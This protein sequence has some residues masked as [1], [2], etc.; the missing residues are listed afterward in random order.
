MKKDEMIYIYIYIERERERERCIKTLD[1]LNEQLNVDGFTISKRGL[2]LRLLPKLSSLEGQ[3]V[4]TVPVKL[5]RAQNDKHAKYINGLFCTATTSHLEEL[6]SMLGPMSQDDKA[7]VPFSLTV[8]NKQ[9][10]S[11]M[12]VEYRVS[13]PDHDWVVDVRRNSFSIFWN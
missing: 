2:Y 12:R 8:A 1:Q 6:A 7:R 13:L 3:H 4:K 9:S 10:P 5:I 11:L